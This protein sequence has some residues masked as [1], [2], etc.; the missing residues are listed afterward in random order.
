MSGRRA[1]TL[2]V[3]FFPPSS[4]QAA[5]VRCQDRLMRGQNEITK[6]EEEFIYYSV[7]NFRYGFLSFFSPSIHLMFENP[8]S[9]SASIQRRRFSFPN[10]WMLDQRCELRIDG[11]SCNSTVRYQKD[12]SEGSKG[13]FQA[14][15]HSVTR[16]VF[17][18]PGLS[19]SVIKLWRYINEH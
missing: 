1:T 19:L 3:S 11:N 14:L 17:R 2:I 16:A 5:E 15:T 18:T 10:C 12:S 13:K 4:I 8:A 9:G 7:I 6:T